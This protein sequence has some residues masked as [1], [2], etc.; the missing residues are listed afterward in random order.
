MLKKILI[1]GGTGTLGSHL[2]RGAVG[3]GHWD[4]VH[5]T[6]HN[7]NPNF[8]KV[9]WH[10]LDARNLIRGLLEKIQPDCIIHTLAISAPDECE[11]KKLDAWQINVETVKEI[12]HFC[13]A[14]QTRLVFTST[15]MVFYGEKGHYSESDSPNPVNF[16]GDTKYEAE[17]EILN[18]QHANCAIVRLSL[19]YGINLNLQP[20]FFHRVLH[21][22]HHGKPVDLF[23]DQYRTM[24]AVA[25][26]AECLLEIAGSDFKGVLHL[27]GPERVNRYEFGLRLAQ[28]LH[29]S[30]EPLIAADMDQSKF[31][32]RRPAD[33]S[34]NS[35]LAA[36]ILKTKICNIED[37]LKSIFEN[38]SYTDLMS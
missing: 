19:L 37:G 3:S 7:V 36:G 38:Q 5:A 23:R 17:N 1:T 31:T 34:L 35:S 20:T 2:V 28:H 11:R 32:A 16:Y 4:S 18:L 6:Y 26:A 25:N 10:Y 29:L 24:M 14:S 12:I 9:F 27:G 33:V 22:L 8:Q 21:A 30:P 13:Q 15:D